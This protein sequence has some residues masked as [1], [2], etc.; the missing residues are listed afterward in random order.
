MRGNMVAEGG[1]ER[2]RAAKLRV[3]ASCV[4]WSTHRLCRYLVGVSFVYTDQERL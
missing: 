4:V 1:W 3:S 2:L